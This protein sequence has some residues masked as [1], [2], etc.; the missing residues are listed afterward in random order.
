ME[1]VLITGANGYIGSHVIDELIKMNKDVIALD[2]NNT[3]IKPSVNFLNIDILNEAQNIKLYEKLDK[4]DNVI[5]LAWQD[6]FNHYAHSHINNMIKHFY[7]I[8]NMIDSGVKSITIMGTVHEIGYHEGKVTEYTPC[9]PLSYYG[10]AKNTLR[11]LVLAYAKD[12]DV[13]I[14][15]LR[16]YYITGD[17]K[18]NHS[19]FTKL[20]EAASQNKTEFP[21]TKGTNQFDFIDV[22][23]LAKM[24]ASASVQNNVEGIIN[25]CSG[26]P[27]SIK[28]KVETFIKEHNLNIKLQYGAFP[29]RKYDSPV[30]Y[31]DNRKIKNIME[32]FNA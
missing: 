17:D 18:N 26:E 5:H 20:L 11:Q 15:W 23:D 22:N 16:A 24:I 14:K 1:K 7:F 3:R 8:Q 9:N 10:I 29:S 19:I 12:K 4:P 21:F 32:D 28:D 13:S 6:G 2:F 30:I 27:I 31:G 25:V